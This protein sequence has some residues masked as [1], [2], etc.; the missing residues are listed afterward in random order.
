VSLTVTTRQ[1]NGRVKWHFQ[2]SGMYTVVRPAVGPDGTVY[3][4]DVDNHL[5]A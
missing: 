2:H 4:L 5:Y 1:S 3:A